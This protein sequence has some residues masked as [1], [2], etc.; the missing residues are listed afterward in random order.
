MAAMLPVLPARLRLLIA[1]PLLAGCA[2]RGAAANAV[3][4]PRVPTTVV[5]V[6]ADTAQFRAAAQA[7]VD[8]FAAEV[9]RARGASLPDPPA[10]QIRTAPQLV[11]YSGSANQITVPWWGTTPPELR[12]AFRTFAGGDDAAAE[13]L[14]RSFFNRFLI[15]HEAGHWY[16]ARANRRAATLY[17]NENEANRLAVA[18]WRT[19]PGA[20]PFLAELERL[21]A[22]AV[23]ALPDPTPAGEDPVAYF[24]AN[25]QTLGRDPLKYGYYQF[26]FMRDALRDRAQLDFARMVA[27]PVK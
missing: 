8:A 6:Y 27:D 25:Y 4:S 26:R 2:S 13:Y 5:P 9:A 16:Q 15:A 21:A 11:F 19:Q 12:G 3:D 22:G 7:V 14:F 23:A 10:I 24:G 20:E 17:Q 18:F 1:L